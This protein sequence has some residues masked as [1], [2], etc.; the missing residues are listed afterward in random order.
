MDFVV[1]DLETANADLSSICQV[2][3]A[4]FSQGQHYSSWESLVNPEDYFDPVNVSI[5]GIDEEKV[6]S[7]PTL[8]EIYPQIMSLLC[9]NIVVSHTPFDRIALRRACGKQE[10]SPIECKWLDSA[11]VVR[12]TWDCFTHSGYGLRNVAAYLDIEYAAH[13][14]LEDARCAGEIL[15]RAISKSGISADQWLIRSAQPVRLPGSLSQYEPRPDGLLF[16]EVL[17]LT[18]TLSMMTRHEAASI[19]ARAGCVVAE[20]VTKHTTLLVVGDQDVR[21]LAGHEKSAKHRKVEELILRGQ[22]IRILTENDFRAAIVDEATEVSAAR[23]A[24]V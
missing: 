1:L 12:R 17:V 14:A 20:G 11:R 22:P 21:R 5:H 19:A 9:G 8:G 23:G 3:I 15:L 7:S 2:G 18:G 4:S 10:L 24:K 16:G 13:N 6:C